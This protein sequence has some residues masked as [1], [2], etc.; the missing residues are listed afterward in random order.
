M[1][2]ISA[3][4]KPY[5]LLVNFDE[6]ELPPPPTPKPVDPA[7]CEATC[8]VTELDCMCDGV[9]PGNQACLCIKPPGSAVPVIDVDNTG[10]CLE[11][12]QM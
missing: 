9:D 10:F 11:F 1:L 7:N 8:S 4:W 6:A 3:A 5:E 2:N 12:T